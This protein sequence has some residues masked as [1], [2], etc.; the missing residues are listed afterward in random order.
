[1]DPTPSRKKKP[2][3]PAF[4]RRDQCPDQKNT[5]E[6]KRQPR[7]EESKIRKKKGGILFPQRGEVAGKKKRVNSFLK[8]KP[9][10]FPAGKKAVN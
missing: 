7:P 9:L 6:R 4:S 8:K 1:M 10:H 5:R 3:I 2:P